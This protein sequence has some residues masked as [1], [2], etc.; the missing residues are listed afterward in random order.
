MN[1]LIVCNLLFFSKEMRFNHVKTKISNNQL[2]K[3]EIY[4][5]CVATIKSEGNGAINKIFQFMQ[6]QP[7]L[8]F[9][10]EDHCDDYETLNQP[11]S[12]ACEK[13]G[14]NS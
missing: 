5:I 4:F 9:S 2:Y 6:K 14:I 7:K 8:N 12:E 10:V 11:L 1:L 3:I 13:A